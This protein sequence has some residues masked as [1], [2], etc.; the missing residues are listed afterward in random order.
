MRKKSPTSAWRRS[1]SSTRRTRD[2]CAAWSRKPA[3]AAAEVA[4]AA[5]AVAAAAVAAAVA[6]ARAA[7]V[8]ACRGEPAVCARPDCFSIPL[9]NTGRNGRV[10]LDR[11]GHSVSCLSCRLYGCAP[12]RAC[13]GPGRSAILSRNASP[14][15]KGIPVVRE[16]ALRR[17]T[18]VVGKVRVLTS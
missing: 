6:A 5:E 14:R 17:R 4:E 2:R 12:R 9:T 1:M 8:A 16:C 3:A 10:R 18:E 7:R 11:P 13:D 15:A